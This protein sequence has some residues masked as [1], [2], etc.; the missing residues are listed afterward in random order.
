MKRNA[1]K[2]LEEWKVRLGRKPLII[3]G[4]R[5]VGKTWLVRE[6]AGRFDNFIEI[7]FDRNP[8]KAQIFLGNDVK[9]SIE[10]L[11]IDVDKDILPGRTLLFFDEIQAVPEMLP[12]L[13]YFYEEFSDLHVIA[14]GSLLEFILAEHEFSMPV[15]RVE[16]MHIGPLDFE[17]FLQ[18]QGQSRLVGFINNYRLGESIPESI[19]SNLLNYLKLYFVIG[20]MP[21][22]IV[23]YLE[24]RNVAAAS[25]EHSAILQTYEDDFA[26]YKKRIYP[27][28]L[29]NT[30]RRLP[31]LVGQK[32]KYVNIDPEER[33]KDIADAMK[34]LEMAKVFSRIRHSYGN[35]VP[36][37]AEVKEKVFKPLFLDV[38]LL[39]A[40]LG[41]NLPEFEI[42][43]DLVMVN[44]GAVAEQFIGQHLLYSRPSYELPQIYYWNREAKSSGAEVDYLIECG[45]TVVPVEVKSGTTG[46][47]KSLQ[48]FIAEKKVGVA[49][50]FN[51]GMPSVNRLETGIASKPKVPYDLISLPMYMVCQTQR[52]MR[53]SLDSC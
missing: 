20:G 47:L 3:R 13:R 17:E 30:F 31:A 32:F 5:Q 34:L 23:Q 1:L 26:R 46:A 49:L 9:R 45:A 42:Q 41:L 43:K 16:Y 2:K 10:L 4:A 53:E 50:R 35:G 38:G 7:N 19:H 44:G 21:A 52:L 12:L 40:S 22:A 24:I 28:R 6:F 29:R 33:S 36:L 8:E 51:A 18:A 48:V 11:Q 39:T 15:G 14:A 37:G 25:R 27:Q